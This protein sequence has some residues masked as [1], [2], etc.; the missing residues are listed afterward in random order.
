MLQ[1]DARDGPDELPG[2]DLLGGLFRDRPPV[3]VR[4]VVEAG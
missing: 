2:D 4:V 3:G 1:A